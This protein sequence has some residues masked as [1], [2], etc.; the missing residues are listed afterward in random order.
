MGIMSRQARANGKVILCDFRGL[1]AEDFWPL[2]S[3]MTQKCLNSSSM[4]L[5]PD[6]KIYVNRHDNECAEAIAET[7]SILA[8]MSMKSLKLAEKKY[9]KK[10]RNIADAADWTRELKKGAMSYDDL[11]QAL[12]MLLIPIEIRR[13]ET[14]AA[15]FG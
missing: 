4:I 8:S 14:E 1:K 3:D 11:A 6:G 5:S 10:Y 2:Y 12:A 13:R 9:R 7:A 15:Y